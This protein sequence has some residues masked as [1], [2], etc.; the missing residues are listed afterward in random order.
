M[1][2]PALW[3]IPTIVIGGFIARQ[4]DYR[5]QTLLWKK[6]YT[7][8]VVLFQI[9]LIYFFLSTDAMPFIYFQF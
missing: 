9:L 6:S 2:I 5:F 1:Y 3:A 8:A 4:V 7:L